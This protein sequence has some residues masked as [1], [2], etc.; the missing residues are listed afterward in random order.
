MRHWRKFVNHVD[1]LMWF[2]FL[3]SYFLMS[4]FLSLF[5]HSCSLQKGWFCW[6]GVDFLLWFWRGIDK[7]QD[8]CEV[9]PEKLPN[10]E[11]KIKNFFEEHLHTDE[12]IRY[13]VGGSGKHFYF[14]VLFFHNLIFWTT[15]YRFVL[16]G[17]LMWEIVMMLGYVYG[18]RKG[19]WLYY[20]LAFTIVSRLIQ[21]T[22]SRYNDMN[23]HW[24]LDV[25]T[26]A[27]V[28][29]GNW[30]TLLL[31]YGRYVFLH[32]IWLEKEVR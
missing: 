30:Q 14:Y 9:C 1:T 19:E 31:Y 6:L 28:D 21:T 16:K 3:N 26:S 18:W 27:N 25:F 23:C 2:V 24:W 29:T 8:F 32:E 13:C 7:F 17:T 22:T 5:T 20:L 11:E 4:V 10:Y 12:E 15:K